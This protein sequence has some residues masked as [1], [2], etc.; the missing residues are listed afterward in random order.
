MN[1]IN[2][3]KSFVIM[4]NYELETYILGRV[5]SIVTLV[6]FPKN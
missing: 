4:K 1:V 2:A 3:P 5:P 6:I